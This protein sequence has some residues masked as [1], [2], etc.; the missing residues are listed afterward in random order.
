M[1][2]VAG[3]Y[4]SPS[5]SPDGKSIAYSDYPL[6]DGHLYFFNLESRKTKEVPGSRG[7]FGCRWSY[8]GNYLAALSYDFRKVALFDIQEQ[9]L[10]DPL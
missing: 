3:D 10:E 9:P 4:H 1:L 5:W 8:D 6:P 2:L 7:Y